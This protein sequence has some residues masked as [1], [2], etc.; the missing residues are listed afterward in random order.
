MNHDDTDWYKTRI[1][2]SLVI[3]LAILFEMTIADFVNMVNA[4]I[5]Q[6]HSYAHFNEA[7]TKTL[8]ISDAKQILIRYNGVRF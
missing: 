4:I 7:E 1:T 6:R 8:W 5:T 2:N 3:D